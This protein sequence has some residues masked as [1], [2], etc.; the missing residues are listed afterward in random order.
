MGATLV[1]ARIYQVAFDSDANIFDITGLLLNGGT[2]D[3]VAN[4]VTVNKTN[5]VTVV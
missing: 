3:A 5:S 2:A 1:W 4:A